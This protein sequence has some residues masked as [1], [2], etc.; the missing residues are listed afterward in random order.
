M[1]ALASFVTRGLDPDIDPA[2]VAAEVTAWR[3]RFSGVHFT[4]PA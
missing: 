2:A 1:P 3:K 4:A